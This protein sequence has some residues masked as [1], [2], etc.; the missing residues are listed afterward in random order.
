MQSIALIIAFWVCLLCYS[1]V[2]WKI[3]KTT[4][5][6]NRFT[7]DDNMGNQIRKQEKNNRAAKS[8]SLFVLAYLLLTSTYVLYTFVQFF[9][10]PP[11]EFL[12]VVVLFCNMGGVFN[13][14]A[15]TYS[16]RH[17]SGKPNSNGNKA[18]HP[19]MLLMKC[20]SLVL[21]N[22]TRTLF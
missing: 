20:F 11:N 2:W 1:G 7:E 15:Y 13:F 4:R 16:R 10:T 14:F 8:M 6:I 21:E 5:L 12:G 9:T 19:H 17:N 22:N 18:G 3:Q